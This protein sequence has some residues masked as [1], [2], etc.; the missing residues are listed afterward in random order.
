[1]D[2]QELIR[3]FKHLA[4]SDIPSFAPRSEMVQ[5]IGSYNRAI[6]NLNSQN[7]DIALITL[8]KL[9]ATYPAFSQAVLLNGICL[10][11]AGRLDESYGQ[12]SHALRNG[13]AEPYLG[14]AE[15]ALSEL[16][17]EIAQRSQAQSSTNNVSRSRS[18]RSS[19]SAPLPPTSQVLEKTTPRGKVRMASEKERQEVIRRGEFAQE[20]E[21]NVRLT[22][23]PIEYLRFAL[24]ALAVM[25]VVGLL[26]FFGIKLASDLADTNRRQLD[27]EN[28]LNWLVTRLERLSA[29]NPAVSGLLSEYEAAFTTATAA[30]VPTTAPT[31]LQTSAAMTETTVPTTSS[32]QTAAPTTVAIDSASLSQANSLYQQAV[33]VQ[34]SDLVAAGNHL[35]AARTLLAAIP[36][37]TTALDVTGNAAA[38][39]ASVESL[40]ESIGQ[41]AAERNRVLG[42]VEYDQKKYDTALTFFSAGFQLYPRAYGGGVAYYCGRCNQLLGETAAAKPYFDYV[43]E[44]FAG[45]DIAV[46][47]AARLKEMGY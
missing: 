12:V 19:S 11:S 16:D 34:G 17:H 41:N 18:D 45:R 42:M 4:S 39:S 37:T 46:S 28:R 32:S 14:Y 1:M 40:V 21:T 20:E 38:L 35:L 47:A 33:A 22:R 7:S 8:R 31:T 15:S 44:N 26:I 25:I 43:V 23:E 9:A 29:D 30:T 3:Q 10:A 13:L 36:A 27:T 24:P 5:A 2:W 6:T